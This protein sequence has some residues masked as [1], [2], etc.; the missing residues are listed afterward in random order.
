M[1]HCHHFK[2]KVDTIWSGKS[3]KSLSKHSI[4]TKEDGKD[5]RKNHRLGF[6][7]KTIVII[8]NRL[9]GLILYR[10]DSLLETR[11]QASRIS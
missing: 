1:G 2:D 3:I 6:T 9:L 7:L 10:N 5:K 11:K 4:Q 8:L